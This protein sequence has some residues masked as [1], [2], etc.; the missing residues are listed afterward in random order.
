MKTLTTSDL[1]NVSGGASKNTELTTALTNIQSSIKDVASQ[2]NSGGF[3][4]S[5]TM[6][7]MGLMMSQRNQGP[8]VVAAGPAP[9]ASGPI[10]NV[11]TRVRRGW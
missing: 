6:L 7:M 10:I 11:S 5:S 2:K 1:T 8:T 4:D 9:A 3:G